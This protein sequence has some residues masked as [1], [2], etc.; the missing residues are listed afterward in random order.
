MKKI[1]KPF[2]LISGIIIILMLVFYLNSKNFYRHNVKREFYKLEFNEIIDSVYFDYS[3]HNSPK[4]IFSNKLSLDLSF[5][6]NS[7]EIMEKS[8]KGWKI[9]KNKNSFLLKYSKIDTSFVIKMS[10]PN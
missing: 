4:L 7:D 5:V 2:L 10:F 6:L 8:K 9:K 1:K 3:D